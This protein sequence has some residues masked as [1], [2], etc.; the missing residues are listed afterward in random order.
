MEDINYVYKQC[1]MVGHGICACVCVCACF[2]MQCAMH[3][4]HAW[5]FSFAV[6][7]IRDF[8][9]TKFPQ[10]ATKQDLLWSRYVVI[11]IVGLNTLWRTAHTLTSLYYTRHLVYINLE[12]SLKTDLAINQFCL[13]WL[14]QLYSDVAT[15]I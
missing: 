11:L 9:S 12:K 13:V 15:Y 1:D 2:S 5:L 7:I 10:K 6:I 3:S 14:I 4:Y 8:C